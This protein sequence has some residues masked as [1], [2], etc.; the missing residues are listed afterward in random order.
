MEYQAEVK[1]ILTGPMPRNI[2]VPALIV[3]RGSARVT[4]S[5]GGHSSKSCIQHLH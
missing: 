1:S 3:V 4:E 5:L 2:W